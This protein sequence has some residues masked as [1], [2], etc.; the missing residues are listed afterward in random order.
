[1]VYI[2]EEGQKNRRVM[3]SITSASSPFESL[4]VTFISISGVTFNRFSLNGY[5]S[6][7]KNSLSTK[8]FI[9]ALSELPSTDNIIFLRRVVRLLVV[10]LDSFSLAFSS[11]SISRSSLPFNILK[12][13]SLSETGNL[14]LNSF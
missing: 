6:L 7:D 13:I 10:S 12:V 1:M 3:G 14:K 5:E 4:T 11:K 8:L 2:P 9:K